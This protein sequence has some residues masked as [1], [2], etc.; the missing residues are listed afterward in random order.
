MTV[1][2]PQSRS[3]LFG[4]GKNLLCLPGF[5][6]HFLGRPACI[7]SLYWQRCSS[8]CSHVKVRKIFIARNAT[9]VI[10]TSTESF[11]YG[12]TA[13]RGP[14]PPHCWRLHDHTSDTPHLVGLIWTRDQL[15]AGIRTHNPSKRAAADP[16]LRPR[17]HW[18]RH[19]KGWA[20]III[21]EVCRQYCW[22]RWNDRNN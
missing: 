20:D 4:E 8:S 19:R 21:Q 2:G 13:P 18:D 11:F 14:R 15:V 9:N 12:S 10:C 6:S 1:F 3:G 22:S 7:C 5:G 16:S 17:G